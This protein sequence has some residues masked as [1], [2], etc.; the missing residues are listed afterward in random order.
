MAAAKSKTKKKWHEP[1]S[2]PHRF[3]IRLT[4]EEYQILIDIKRQQQIPMSVTI[5]MAIRSY[6]QQL[7]RKGNIL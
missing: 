6:A 1:L 4:K 3:D 7:K 5:R 2:L